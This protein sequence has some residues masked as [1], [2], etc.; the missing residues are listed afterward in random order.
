MFS[1][2][3]IDDE[4]AMGG[5]GPIGVMLAYW[6]R[7]G[8]LSRFTLDL[9]EPMR[10]IPSL[11]LHLSLS[12]QGEMFDAFRALGLPAFHVDTFGGALGAVS[13]MARLPAVGRSLHQYVERHRISVFLALMPHVWMPFLGPAIRRA[14][15]RNVVVVHDATPH[16]GES[17]AVIDR[18]LRRQARRADR[19]VTLSRHVA[20]ELV[21]EGVCS[22]ERVTALFHPALYARPPTGRVRAP[23][24]PFRL[25]FLGRILPYKGLDRLLEA[26]W[27]L[28][29]RGLSLRLSIVGDGDLRHARGAL[30]DPSI[31]ITNRWVA[32]DEIPAILEHHDALV[33]P[34]LE[35][36]QS[37]VIAA[38]LGA[39]LPVIAT[40]VGG[41]IEQIIPGE[42]GLFAKDTSAE[43]IADAIEQ[44]V[45]SREL[46]QRCVRGATALLQTTAPA[47][48]ARALAGVVRDEA[49][50]LDPARSPI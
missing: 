23:R 15:A 12:R 41:L 21:A 7:R 32:D 22:P 6:G 43:A 34:Y 37:G 33:L 38:A 46:Y 10:R 49:I 11:S 2:H 20:G 1:D 26:F 13:G 19:V 4:A 30:D 44:L 14:G 28:R 40:P 18:L 17:H 27:Q 9:C 31:G 8:A 29:G 16:P 5:A 47:V 36:S 3:A 42:S 39:R 25:L 35:A 24:T 48:F 45:Q 50:A